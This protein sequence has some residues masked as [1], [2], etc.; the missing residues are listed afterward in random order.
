MEIENGRLDVPSIPCDGCTQPASPLTL[1]T[2]YGHEVRYCAS[3]LEVYQSFVTTIM[4][5]EQRRQRE[6][7][8]WQLERRLH[9][10]L[11]LMPM[12][13]PPQPRMRE[14]GLVLG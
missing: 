3:C 11:R 12:D 10:P 8:L 6:L 1:L 14:P 7:D 4:H 9:V 13:L 5:E 2:D